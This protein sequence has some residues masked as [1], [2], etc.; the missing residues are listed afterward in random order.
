MIFDRLR[1]K[2]RIGRILTLAS[3]LLFSSPV[4]AEQLKNGLSSGRRVFVTAEAGNLN[5]KESPASEKY[6][7]MSVQRVGVGC[8]WDDAISAQIGIRSGSGSGNLSL[9]ER[10][11]GFWT[12]ADSELSYDLS[13][14]GG[15]IQIAIG[16]FD[17]EERF[18]GHIG[19]GF[20]NDTYDETSHFREGER[21]TFSEYE[22]EEEI[23]RNTNVSGW[24]V[25]GRFNIN[26]NEYLGGGAFVGYEE[27]DNEEFP[28]GSSYGFYGSLTF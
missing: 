11:S 28:G 9:R 3:F 1:P 27:N 20:H 26:L 19:L 18:N 4:F 10:D 12:E 6:G 16:N 7:T 21:G 2:G 8:V 24:S 17:E 23:K 13:R 25:F 22:Y 5:F 15:D 14:N